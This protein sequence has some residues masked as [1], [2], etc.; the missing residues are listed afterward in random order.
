MNPV[1]V[2]AIVILLAATQSQAYFIDNAGSGL[3]GNEV[4]DFSVFDTISF[5][6]NFFSDAPIVV[7]V[8]R[9]QGDDDNPVSFSAIVNNLTGFS[10]SS[11][12][13]R[14]GAGASLSQVGDIFSLTAL[15]F[16]PAALDA[17]VGVTSFE[18]G[19]TAGFELG[20]V[21][22]DP[23]VSPWLLDVSSLASGDRFEIEF[24]PTVLTSRVPEPATVW[25]LGA[26]VL[27]FG[28]MRRRC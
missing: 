6:A 1:K 23:S 22:G 18:I 16:V 11:F 28:A 9:E 20:D 5:D 27:G 3:N 17:G 15:D 8:E 12:S 14:V 19:E 21:F 13:V 4:V 25:L 7:S 24:N 10:W 26:A 2:L